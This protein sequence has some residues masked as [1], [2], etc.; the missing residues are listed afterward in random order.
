MSRRQHFRTRKRRYNAGMFAKKIYKVHYALRG[1]SIAWR[2]ELSF[3]IQVVGALA[4]LGLGWFLSISALEW[5]LITFAVGFVLAAEVFNTALEELCDKFR[6]D[7]DPHIGK[8]KDL[9]AAAVLLAS[10]TAF[11]VGLVIFVPHLAAWL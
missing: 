8:I 4:A 2:E 1:L 3:R 6:A 11:V 5:I 7:P 9:S 10:T